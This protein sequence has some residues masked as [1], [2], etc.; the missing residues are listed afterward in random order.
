MNDKAKWLLNWF[1]QNS[2][3]PVNPSE[4]QLEVNYFEAGLIDSLGVINLIVGIEE[5]FDIRF[6]ERHFQD[7][8]FSTIGGLSDIIQELSSP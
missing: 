7:R 8:R 2:S 6:N 3:I 5:H 4:E 1:S